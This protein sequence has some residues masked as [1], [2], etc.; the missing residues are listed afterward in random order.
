MEE[1][2]L[3]ILRSYAESCDSATKK[4]INASFVGMVL[5]AIVLMLKNP[6][7]LPGGLIFYALSAGL[8]VAFKIL[9]DG[10][11]RHYYQTKYDS[12]YRTHIYLNRGGWIKEA[13]KA[14]RLNRWVLLVALATDLRD[15]ARKFL[16]ENKIG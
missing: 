14:F 3:R 10:K 5:L 8:L 9:L 4:L 15:R 2:T 11:I 16:Q 13:N 7:A 6:D 12:S 1:R